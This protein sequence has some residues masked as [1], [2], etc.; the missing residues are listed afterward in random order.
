VNNTVKPLSIVSEGAMKSRQWWRGNNSCGNV[1]YTSDVPG[2]DK[3]KTMH[4]GMMYRDFTV[5]NL[6]MWAVILQTELSCIL[7]KST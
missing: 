2:S 5:Y 4:V 6:I 1:I 7:W 3:V